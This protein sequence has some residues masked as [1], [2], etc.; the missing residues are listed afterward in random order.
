VIDIDPAIEVIGPQSCVG[1]FACYNACAYDAVEM[2]QSS[3]GFYRPYIN[4]NCTDCGVC[5][6]FCPVISPVELQRRDFDPKFYAAWSRDEETRVGS[7]SGGYSLNS[8]PTRWKG[9]A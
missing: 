2:K 9:G 8:L 3:E 1:C 5:Q 4:E 7:S 6:E